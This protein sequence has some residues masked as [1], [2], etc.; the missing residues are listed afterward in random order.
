MISYKFYNQPISHLVTA[1]VLFLTWFYLPVDNNRN[2]AE[3]E[4][5]RQSEVSYL[6][7]N[8]QHIQEEIA[9]NRLN[10]VTYDKAPV[11]H[12]PPPPKGLDIR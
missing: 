10:G 3:I 7:D 12:A 9:R 1:K 8:D 4:E 11:K 6:A 2:G 5:I